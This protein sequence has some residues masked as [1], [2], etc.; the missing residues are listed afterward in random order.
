MLRKHFGKRRRRMKSGRTTR[1]S[2]AR[3][4]SKKTLEETQRIKI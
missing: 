4:K 3:I 2:E 1:K